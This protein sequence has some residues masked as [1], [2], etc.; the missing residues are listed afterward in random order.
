NKPLESVDVNSSSKLANFQLNSINLSNGLS[1]SNFNM[2]AGEEVIIS[3][4][5][6]MAELPEH[7]IVLI[8]ELELG[9][10]PKAQKVLIEKLFYIVL[11]K[12]LQLIFTTHS[13]F[14]FDAMPK[15]ARVLLKKPKDNLEVYYGVSSSL[16][17]SALTGEN[18][19]ELTLYVEDKV[20]QLILKKLL[21]SATKKRID[22]VDVGSKE[23]VVRMV[24]AHYR[25]QAL[26]KA[27][28]IADGDLTPKELKSWYSK[29]V[30][31]EGELMED[32]YEQNSKAMFSKLPGDNA[33]EKYILEKLKS[34]D[35]FVAYLDDSDEF[36][37]FVCN[38]LIL[39]DHHD[40]FRIVALELGDDEGEVRSLMVGFVLDVYRGDFEVILEFII[41]ELNNG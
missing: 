23:N 4:I 14:L 26:G 28:G 20:A 11:E 13:P 32:V 19:K 29:Y 5:S 35:E 22:I 9:L 8:E 16:A 18:L 38:E 30:L 33:P 2:G 40:L 17:F 10:H 39:S 25:N 41:K 31:K 27:I 6:R 21:N 24:G 36:S 37:D 15:E 3:I 7:S 12:K 34:D 1:Y